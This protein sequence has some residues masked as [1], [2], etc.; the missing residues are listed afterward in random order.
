MMAGS[1]VPLSE[2]NRGEPGASS[3]IVKFAVRWP[4]PIG[5]TKSEIVQLAGGRNRRRAIIG[6]TEI[7]GVWIT[8]SNRRNVERCGPRVDDGESLQ[9]RRP[10]QRDRWERGRGRREG[11][12]RTGCDA[13]AAQGRSLRASG[14]VVRNRDG[15]GAHAGGERR[16]RNDYRAGRVDRDGGIARRTRGAVVAGVR[17]SKND[18]GDAQGGGAGILHG[19]IQ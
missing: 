10:S 9:C 3:V 6:E 18:A 5:L 4:G 1:V 14:S 16:E 8:E 17:A 15:C 12:T 11:S 19:N 13:R 7:R 2:I